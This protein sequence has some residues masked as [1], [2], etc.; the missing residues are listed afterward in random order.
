[1]KHLFLLISL[2]TVSSLVRAEDCQGYIIKSKG[3]T[4]RGTVDVTIVKLAINKKKEINF[5]DMWQM[6]KFKEGTAKEKKL[7]AGD[8]I[9]YG[10]DYD[11]QSYHFEVLDVQANS[12]QKAPKLLS[13]MLNDFRF[14]VL[15]AKEGPLPIYKEYWNSEQDRTRED[16]TGRTTRTI[17]TTINNM[18]L[19]VKN[20][21]GVFVD[22]APTTLGGNKKLKDFLEKYLKLEDEFLKTV[23]D[24]ARF[25][26]AE[27]ILK[28][29]NDW[30]K[31]KG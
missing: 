25:D 10:F 3:D 15:R 8:I 23:D 11:G 18:E 28:K 27:D 12:G 30:K 29:Y 24:K 6:I 2:F 17:T 9:G 13:R 21:D 14:F 26:D 16:L 5:G 4:V 19:Y 1:M 22:I 7:K 20:T 31:N